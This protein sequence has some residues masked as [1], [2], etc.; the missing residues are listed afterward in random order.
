MASGTGKET[1]EA[2]AREVL[3][4]SSEEV[5]SP[6]V[7]DLLKNWSLDNDFML[8]MNILAKGEAEA[9]GAL[10]RRGAE[11]G[12]SKAEMAAYSSLDD[13]MRAITE[14]S[15]GKVVEYAARFGS[16]ET[17]TQEVVGLGVRIIRNSTTEGDAALLRKVVQDFERQGLNFFDELQRAGVLGDD[18]FQQ[19]FLKESVDAMRN[20]FARNLGSEA[21]EGTVRL[22]SNQVQ[23]ILNQATVRMTEEQ[24]EAVGRLGIQAAEDGTVR[25]TQQQAQRLGLQGVEA[26]ADG[27]VKLTQGQLN[28]I[29]SQ[30]GQEVGQAT[31]RMTEQEIAALGRLGLQAAEDGTIKLTQ[32]QADALAREGL[33]AAAD[34]TIKLTQGQLGQLLERAGQEAGEATI[35]MTQ[36]ELDDIARLAGGLVDDTFRLSEGQV[37]QLLGEAT[38]TLSRSQMEQLGKTL[39]QSQLQQLGETLAGKPA[40]E[41][42]ETLTEKQ[43]Q[44]LAETLT[45]RQLAELMGTVLEGGGRVVAEDYA[46]LGSR[47]ALEAMTKKQF[48]NHLLDNVAAETNETLITRALELGMTRAEIASASSGGRLLEAVVEKAGG[49]VV[50]SSFA[51]EILAISTR[52]FSGNATAADRAALRE[53][54]AA[55]ERQGVN[56]F[57]DLTRSG[58]AST[59]EGF[60]NVLNKEAVD[61]LENFA[62][63]GAMGTAREG[64][65]SLSQ[66]QA[67]ALAETLTER[68]LQQLSEQLATGQGGRMA[69]TLTE[70]QLREVARNLSGRQLAELAETLT[71]KQAQELAET[72]TERQL[73]EM[74]GTAIERGLSQQLGETFSMS[75]IERLGE[76]FSQQEIARLAETLA[77]KEVPME[78]AETLTERQ[79]AALAETLTEKQLQQLGETLIEAGG[80]EL[81]EDVVGVGS[82]EALEKMSRAQFINHLLDTSAREQG[83]ALV[84]RALE[85]GASK[86]EVLTAMSER[87]LLELVIDKSGLKVVE[88]SFAREILAIST[89]VFSGNATAADR[90]ALREMVAAAERQGVN[91]FE[92]LAR[93]G[94]SS[95]AEGFQNVLNKEAVDVLEN[96]ARSGAMGTAREGAESLSQR[97]AAALA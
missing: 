41:L 58:T 73:A 68:Q 79:V 26:A 67:A 19:L 56:F 92:D 38:E 27:T 51:R 75:Q 93:S 44:E 85:L 89:R 63:S 37:S 4:E 65:E 18:G 46:G 8:K 3:E 60:Q 11:L 71:E 17:L 45:E 57:E 9:M 16:G 30:T 1:G 53:M 2:L 12:M 33:Q 80:R 23:N 15:G 69:E 87:R 59:A 94:T 74:A 90:A 36:Q 78:F 81:A 24:I 97:Q 48:V 84:N 91:F 49:K 13:F 70:S 14:R 76:T 10:L 21:A 32:A 72:L 22:S 6:G 61:V 34:G 7:R 29:M 83:Q 35:R 5:V 95:T 20:Y 62:R 88:S 28:Q 64:A 86:A 31:V 39:S 66:R 54:V 40:M 52:V 42:A 50:E 96:F 25:L 43:V 47:E 82:R 77:G 55:A